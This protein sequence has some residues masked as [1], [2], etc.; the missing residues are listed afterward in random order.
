MT[1]NPYQQYKKTQ[2]DTANQGKLIVMLYDGA[3][4]FINRAIDLMPTKRIEEIHTNII[5][6]QDII[7]ELMTSLNM[8]V[9]DISDRLLSIYIYIHKKL[10]E[11]NV[12]KSAEPLIEVKKYL[13]ELREAWNEA[14]KKVQTDVVNS[15]TGGVNIAT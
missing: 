9:G 15:D 8:D 5:K 3:L 14:S 11:A 7:S 6:A 2:I 10:V 1:N 12:K 13:M 4:K